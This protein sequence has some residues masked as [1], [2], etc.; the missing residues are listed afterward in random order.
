V[1]YREAFSRVEGVNFVTPASFGDFQAYCRQKKNK[2][3]ISK[4]ENG[5]QGKGIFISKNP[6]VE[7]LSFSVFSVN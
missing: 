6:K 5:C 1:P 3:F 2:S 4:P 7:R